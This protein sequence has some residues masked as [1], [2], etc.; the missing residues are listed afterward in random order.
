MAVR[1]LKKQL[2][3]GAAA[4]AAEKKTAAS[5][6]SSLSYA[7]QKA[8]LR[9][10][11]RTL[12]VAP[13]DVPK[14]ITALVSER[15]SLAAQAAERAKAGPV[16]ADAL[17]EKAETIAH[18]GGETTLVVAE[19]VVGGASELRNL[20]DQIRKKTKS[21]AVLLAAKT[22]DDAVTLV[23]GLSR[24]LVAAGQNAGNWVRE[25]AKIVGGSGGGKP[26]LAQA[27]GKQPENIGAALEAARNAIHASLGGG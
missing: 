4:A 17:L 19:A 2:S 21:S 22:G 6:T 5:A 25:T 3:G 1:D 18:A 23:A 27:G 7:E 11:A 14:R 10:T 15:E 13:F 8:A 24:D 20:I 26:D 12:N 9:E 16:S